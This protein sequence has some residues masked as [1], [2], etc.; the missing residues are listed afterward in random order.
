MRE[1]IFV[2][3]GER[4]PVKSLKIKNK[5]WIHLRGETHVFDFLKNESGVN[6]ETSSNEHDGQILSPMPGKILKINFTSQAEVKEGDVILLMEAMKMEYAL[7][8]PFSGVLQKINCQVGEQ[9]ELNQL[10]ASVTRKE[11]SNG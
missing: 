1:Q 8:A 2:I 9:V 7:T 10:L 11:Q 5:L 3:N 6:A 4:C